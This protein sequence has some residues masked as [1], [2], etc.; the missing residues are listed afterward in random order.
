MQKKIYP[1]EIHIYTLKLRNFLQNISDLQENLIASE[2][3]RA[4]KF[5]FNIDRSNFIVGR[6][7]LRKLLSFYLQ[8]IPSEIKLSLN[9]FGKPILDIAQHENLKFNL[10]HS[11]NLIIYSFCLNSEIGIDIEKI[12][13]SINHLEI[14]EHYFT[15]TEKSYLKK[16][17]NSKQLINRFFKIWT[18]KES[19]LKA[20]GTG[21]LLDLKQID[22]LNDQFYFNNYTFANKLSN[23]KLW[24]IKDL[25]IDDNYSAAIAYS[26]NSKTI[27]RS[28]LELMFVD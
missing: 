2:I 18:R 12:E 8:S 28:E 5:K 25:A 3:E 15:E 9:Q 27:V 20:I 14:A 26:G 4:N 16:S 10:S 22:I 13:T 19:L 17:N 11:G 7:W 1:G 23:N 24:Y 6:F 21:L